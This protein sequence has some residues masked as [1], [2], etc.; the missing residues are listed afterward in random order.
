MNR[1]WAAADQLVHII[2]RHDPS[3]NG[4]WLVSSLCGKQL[5]HQRLAGLLPGNTDEAPTCLMCVGA[6]QHDD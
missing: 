1:H 5:C 6:P 2:G 3:S 4:R